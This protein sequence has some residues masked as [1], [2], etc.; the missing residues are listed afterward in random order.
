M[1]VLRM[2]AEAAIASESRSWLDALEYALHAGDESDFDDLFVADTCWR[3][4]VSLTWDTCQFWGRDAVRRA[5]F[6]HATPAGLSNLRLDDDRSAP[7]TAE[8]LGEPVIEVFFSF[9]TNVGT[10]KGFARL[11]PGS[12]ARVGLR[13]LMIATILVS[14]DCAPEPVGRHP[15][16]GFDPAYPG[17]TWGEWTAAKSDFSERDPDVL[18]I[19]GSHSGLSVGARFERKGTSYLIVEKNEKPGDMWRGRYESLALHTPTWMNDLPYIPL[20]E[21]W[22]TFLPKDRWAD[23]LDSYATLMNLNFWGSTEALSASFDGASREW[24][25]QL[26]LADGSTRVMRPKHLVLAVGGVGGRPRIPELPGLKE[27]TGKVLHSSTFKSGSAYRGKQVM[28]VG[29]STTAHDICL[30]LYR[31]GASPTMAQRGPTCVVNIDEVLKFTAD[32]DRLSTDEADQLRSSM[33]LPLMIKRAQAYTLTTESSHAALHAGLREAGQK[34]TI[35]HDNTGWSMKLF[36]DSAGYYLNV[37]ASEAIVEGKIKMLDFEKIERFVPDGV[38]LK[39]GSVMPL[40]SIVLSTGYD[41]LSC[42]IEAL[43][44]PKVAQRFDR[45]VGVADDGEYRT[46]SRPT[47]QPHLW[48]INGGIV[49][50]RKSSD[51]LAL[52]II[53]QM[54]GLVPSLV[55]QPDGSL[56]PL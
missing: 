38:S 40:D 41:D 52:Q 9:D 3:D 39:D 42:D 33:N 44:G 1:S 34:L 48:L 49:D 5:M 13:A 23:W 47:A 27:F 37:G 14:L 50:A 20:P 19:G 8:F 55:R 12:S 29:A 7:K 10:G 45:C 36:R 22:P 30:D 46:M 16:L 24:E 2:R 11:T 21:C 18:I 35:G 54:K 28:V 31:N 53:A 25:V 32:Y 17:Q 26:R 4:V 6:K 43:L 51:I 56:R 15:G